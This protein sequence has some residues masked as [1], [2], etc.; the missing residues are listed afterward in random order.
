MK[1]GLGFHC[2][3]SCVGVTAAL[4]FFPFFFFSIW[5]LFLFFEL[6]RVWIFPFGFELDFLSFLFAC[7]PEKGI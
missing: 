3:S 4:P 6:V 2:S 1:L 7:S 5:I